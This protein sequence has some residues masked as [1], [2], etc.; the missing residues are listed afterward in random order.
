MTGRWVATL[1][2]ADPVQWRLLTRVMLRIDFRSSSP[3]SMGVPGKKKQ[4]RLPWAVLLVYSVVGMWL[5]IAAALFSDLLTVSALVLV[6]VGMLVA[7]A[8]LIDFN[9]VVLSP[10]D[11]R[12]LSPLPIS[13]ATYFAA[14]LTSILIYTGAIGGLIGIP[15]ACVLLVRHGLA[16][17]LGLTL[18]LAG[19]V[20]WT[21]LPLV[22]AYAVLIGRVHPRRLRLAL[23]SLQLVLMMAVFSAPLLMPDQ[24]QGTDFQAGSAVFLV[25]WSWFAGLPSLLSGEWNLPAVGG[26][27]AGLVTIVLFW[28]H[29]RAR[30]SLSGARRLDNLS[31]AG[32]TTSRPRRRL[33]WSRGASAEQQAVATL[34]RAQFR[35]DMNFRLAVLSVVPLTALYLLMSLRDGPLPNPIVQEG[36]PPGGRLFLIHLLT[37]LMPLTLMDSLVRSDSSAASWIFFATPA[38]RARL[39]VGS[40]LCVSRFFVAPYAALLAAIFLWSWGNPGHALLHAAAIGFLAHLVVQFRVLQSPR[41]PFSEGRRSGL[42]LNQFATVIVGAFVVSIVLPLVFGLAYMGPYFTAAFIVLLVLA[43]GAFPRVVERTVR[44][45]VERLEFGG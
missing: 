6:A 29:A 44:A 7:M 3:L 17:A 4:T 32:E 22:I 38:D 25:P 16:A 35:S 11:Y 1:A 40:G 33:W 42:A 5:A 21:V 19:T 27:L 15:A 34:V 12:V 18:G 8:I 13:S 20:V 41:I 31:A 14:R 28:R 37:V 10:H 43:A 2:G 9:S 23:S 26:L 30:I 39:V 24:M 36:A 45:R